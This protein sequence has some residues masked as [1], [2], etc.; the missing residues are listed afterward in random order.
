MAWIRLIKSGYGTSLKL[1]NFNI[2]FTEP[3]N[4]QESK[5]SYE[6]IT[7]GVKVIS[8]DVYDIED[9]FIGTFDKA[10]VLNTEINFGIQ[11]GEVF[12]NGDT[13]L[14]VDEL[15]QDRPIEGRIGGGQWTTDYL[16]S[17]IKAIVKSYDCR[18]TFEYGYS[19]DCSI[20]LEIEIPAGTIKWNEEVE[21]DEIY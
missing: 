10:K 8:F 4:I 18:L 16:N 3:L 13:I 6:S 2:E 17:D 19:S 1:T 20:Y 15:F 21:E 12:N 11:I 7:K 5:L 9:H 14:K